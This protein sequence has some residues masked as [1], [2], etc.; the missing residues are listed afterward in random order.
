MDSPNHLSDNL[1]SQLVGL[2][3]QQMA[4]LGEIKSDHAATRQ[5][6]QDLKDAL[7][8]PEG[9]VTKLERAREWESK[10]QWIHTSLVVPIAVLINV[11]IRKLTGSN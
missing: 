1:L 7:A 6:V 11:A 4:M 2:N 9:R 8:G 10:K 5:A 3:G